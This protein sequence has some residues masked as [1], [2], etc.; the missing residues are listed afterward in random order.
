MLFQVGAS[1]TS[2]DQ[3]LLVRL[4]GA[5]IWNCTFYCSEGTGG[6]TPLAFYKITSN[7]YPDWQS[8][9]TMGAADTNE[10]LNSYVENCTWNNVSLSSF[11]LG[12][13]SRTV[14][15]Y[16]TFSNSGG[17]SHGQDTGP[18]GVR[19]Y[20]FYNNTFIFSTTG[21]DPAGTAFPLNIN[22]WMLLRGGT[23]VIFNNVFPAISSEHWGNKSSVVFGDFN[24]NQPPNA[25]PCQTV[26]PSAEQ[27]GQ[28][29]VGVSGYAWQTPGTQAVDGTGYGT[30]PVYAW[31]NTGSGA[32]NVAIDDTTDASFSPS[33]GNGQVASNYLQAGRDYIVGT[34]KP[35]YTPAALSES[36]GSLCVW[37]ADAHANSNSYAQPECLRHDHNQGNRDRS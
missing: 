17:S 16:N 15:R 13:N 7:P 37:I 12:P 22:W 19:Q 1:G 9:D 20:E 4:N 14:L 18:N 26:Y 29:Y 8:A 30:E 32:T 34:V 35:G 23:G 2:V 24:I 27:V 21:T 33:C 6:E 28:T 3:G 25:V 11:D 5:V 36:A 31:G 10:T